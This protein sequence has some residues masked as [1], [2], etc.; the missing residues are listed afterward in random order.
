M[1]ARGLITMLD[2]V[3]LYAT[4]QE[5]LDWAKR[6]VIE[7]YHTHVYAGITG[8][9]GGTSH[10]LA[11]QVI[12]GKSFPKVPKFKSTRV[13]HIYTDSFA[14]TGTTTTGTTTTPVVETPQDV[15][16]TPTTGGDGNGGD[17][18]YGG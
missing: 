13:P 10:E 5:A 2:N 17:T 6:Y 7:G 9:M 18:G 14:A 12:V 1:S 15:T 8:Y 4:K 3:P 11:K 16:D